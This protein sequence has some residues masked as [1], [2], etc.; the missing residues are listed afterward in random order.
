[1]FVR[2]L[3]FNYLTGDKG[4]QHRIQC[5]VKSSEYCWSLEELSIESYPVLA[6]CIS[7]KNYKNIQND[8]QK[9]I[10]YC[11]TILGPLFIRKSCLFLIC[12]YCG[13]SSAYKRLEPTKKS[14]ET[15]AEKWI[16]WDILV[17]RH[18]QEDT[19]SN[20]LF[21]YVNHQLL[22]CKESIA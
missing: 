11:S 10:T 7:S 2:L 6:G 1:M 15:P 20:F 3:S 21:T 19:S 12:S 14:K 4:G 5:T 18:D 16:K 17:L 8:F 9:T 22:L 13:R